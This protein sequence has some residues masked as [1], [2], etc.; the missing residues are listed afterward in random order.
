MRFPKFKGWNFHKEGSECCTYEFNHN[1]DRSVT[2]EYDAHAMTVVATTHFGDLEESH[3]RSYPA[4]IAGDDDLAVALNIAK[5]LAHNEVF[6]MPIKTMEKKIK[7]CEGIERQYIHMRKIM[8]RLI[9][10]GVDLLDKD[11]AVK[12]LMT[13]EL[14][15]EN[16]KRYIENYEALVSGS[17]F[18][19]FTFSHNSKPC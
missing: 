17:R 10:D 2:V 18:D 1:E 16:V 15:A 13:T 6:T 4:Y 19:Y 8:T 9:A 5:S 11:S 14:A 12:V 3:N 7:S